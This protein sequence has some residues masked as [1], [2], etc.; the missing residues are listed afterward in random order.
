MYNF[1]INKWHFIQRIPQEKLNP[2]SYSE[3]KINKENKPKTT[4]I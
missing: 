4:K 1:V 2:Q 3:L